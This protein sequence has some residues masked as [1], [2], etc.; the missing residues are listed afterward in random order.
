MNKKLAGFLLIIMMMLTC[1]TGCEMSAENGEKKENGENECETVL[2]WIV[3]DEKTSPYWHAL[4]DAYTKL[5]KDIRIEMIDLGSNNYQTTLESEL[6]NPEFECDIV[7]L[8]DVPGYATLVAKRVLEPLN[9]RIEADKVD[10]SVYNGTAEQI[11]ADGQL[12]QIPFRS[13]IWLLY[14]N[15]DLFDAAGVPYP[16]NDMTIEEYDL[17]V[18]LIAGRQQGAGDK[19]IYGAHYHTWRSTVQLFGILD[20]EHTILDGDYG[21]T[22]AYYETVKGQEADGI[23]RSYIDINASELHYSAAFAEGNTATMNM[24]SW[25]IATLI[26]NLAN[27]EYD[28]ALCGNW[29]IVR[30]PHPEG[31]EEGTTL[32]TITGLAIS[33]RSEHK[34]AAWDFIKFAGSEEGAKALA[35]TGTFPAIMN[36][37]IAEILTGVDGFPGDKNSKEAIKVK[38]IYLEAPYEKDISKLNTILDLYHKEIM[39]GA[40]SVDEGIRKMNEEVF[41]LLQQ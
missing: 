41:E 27:G 16:G 35:K 20:G 13:D 3:W 28:K 34:D 30:Y 1:C 33:S 18:R 4:A 25:Y 19:K 31:V 21:F 2:R 7:T 29:G 22:K 15:K 11:T 10:L 36:D 26:S 24:G 17:L 14:Y 12:Y 9:E 6:F 38:K 40:V 32:G 37:E 8:K 23:C 39:N 5:H